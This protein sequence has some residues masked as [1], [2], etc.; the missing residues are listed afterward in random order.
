[1]MSIFDE[2]AEARDSLS[3]DKELV[4]TYEVLILLPSIYAFFYHSL[5]YYY[6]KFLFYIVL[7]P[8]LVS[9]ICL[10]H[11][12]SFLSPIPD[13]DTWRVTP[14]SGYE[15]IAPSKNHVWYICLDW[16]VYCDFVLRCILETIFP[17]CLDFAEFGIY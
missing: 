13:G 5:F 1:M 17:V 10:M 16:N 3:D 8:Y 11:I 14:D 2:A 4:N 9:M 12:F 6:V 7:L 15:L